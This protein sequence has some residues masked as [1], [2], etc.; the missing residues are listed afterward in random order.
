M[1]EGVEIRGGADEFEAAVIAIV[2]DRIDSEE[3]AARSGVGRRGPE[4]PAWVRA[5]PQEIPLRS[6]QAVFPDGP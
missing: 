4:L 5:L 2:L 6:P 1:V 3:S